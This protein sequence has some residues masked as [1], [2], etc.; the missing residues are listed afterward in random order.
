[1]RLDPNSTLHWFG[2]D[3]SGLDVSDR[4]VY[5]CPSAAAYPPYYFRVRHPTPLGHKNAVLG[6]KIIIILL[7]MW[8]QIS[9]SP[10]F[11][12]Y[13]YCRCADGYYGAPPHDCGLCPVNCAC[14]MGRTLSWKRGFY[15]ILNNHCSSLTASIHSALIRACFTHFTVLRAVCC[16]ICAARGCSPSDGGDALH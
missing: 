12:G 2:F 3:Q 15:P 5:Y 8:L 9:T 13:Q 6:L 10:E 4:R 11:Y 1:M 7:P 14:T 16:M